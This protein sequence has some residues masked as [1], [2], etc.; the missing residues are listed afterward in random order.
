MPAARLVVR[1][2]ADVLISEAFRDVVQNVVLALVQ[3]AS[4]LVLVGREVVVL[5]RHHVHR[6]GHVGTDVFFSSE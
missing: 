3:V 5:L 1:S 2:W 4:S 6:F